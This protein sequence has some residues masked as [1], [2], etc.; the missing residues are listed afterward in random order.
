GN[1][2]DIRLQGFG[3]ILPADYT[4]HY[5]V[6]EAGAYN[7]NDHGVAMEAG[8]FSSTL[9]AG[10]GN[11]VTEART[12]QQPYANPVVLG[13]V[14]SYN[15]PNWSTFWANGNSRQASPSSSV[16]H[17]GKNVGED[18]NT[19]RASETIGYLVF[20]A[21][22][23]IINGV[24]FVAGEGGDNVKGIGNGPTGF[25]YPP[26]G[27]NNPDVAIVSMGSGMDATD[28]GWPILMGANSVS[29]AGLV[30]N[31]DEDQTGNLERNHSTETLPFVVFEGGPVNQLPNAIASADQTSGV[32]SLLVNVDGTASSD[33]DGSLVSYVW[34]F[35]DGNQASG[36][37]T[38][39]TFG[40]GIF[41]VVLTVTDDQGATATDEITITVA[42]P[43][44]PPLAA[45]SATPDP[46]TV[47]L[48]IQFDGS[49]SSDPDGNIQSYSWDF[50]DGNGGTGIA[51]SHTY[52]DTGWFAVSLTVTDDDG[53]VHTSTQTLRVDT[54]VV[55]TGITYELGV[56]PAV[57]NAWQS[58]PLAYSYT[59][60]VVVTTVNLSSGTQLPVVSRVRNADGN[61]F[62]VKVD[63]F[64]GHQPSGYSVHYF[65]VEAGTYTLANDG[66]AMEAGTFESTTTAGRDNWVTEARNFQQAYS[67]PVVLGQVMTAN[68][69]DWSVFWANGNSRAA[70]PT[71]SAF[72][73]G[74]NVGEDPDQIRANETIGY[75]VFESGQG[76]LSGQAFDAGLG[77]D[78]V[79][80]LENSANGFVYPVNGLT[81]PEVAIL[82][83][84]AGMDAVDGGWPVLFGASPVNPGQINLLIDEDQEESTERRHSTESVTYV[85]FE[86]SSPRIPKPG[87][88]KV[89]VFPNPF[90]QHVHLEVLNWQGEAISLQWYNP[91]GQQILSESLD[92]ANQVVE[93]KEAWPKG[94]Y[95]LQVQV[96]ST[97]QNFR[98]QKQ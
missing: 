97:I 13:Q 75:V 34:D 39:H 65:V 72:H 73:A 62:E 51:P 11:W 36:A 85:V 43:N 17:A 31:I 44:Q 15:D 41:Q 35:G 40:I 30:L 71:A 60:M 45:F 3:G 20:E 82:S 4:I 54:P 6:V 52:A 1:S 74:K 61:S 96:G 69:P 8:T 12:Y 47:G 21:G 68:D 25:P 16:F 66:V 53:A 5:L 50:D 42:G 64:A 24:E 59:N 83:M 38:S 22:A 63:G 91:L 9:T 80:G 70:S 33:P 27:M 49:A 26:V 77:A 55:A 76:T 88:I 57:G 19:T 29:S 79:K 23:G 98:L 95:L 7:L 93:I 28:G 89:R 58:I 46:A 32:T 84:G 94:M 10:I 67:S 2:F 14:M 86:G 78:I 81:N 90:D 92:Q 18:P 48:P 87:A 56:L 37:T